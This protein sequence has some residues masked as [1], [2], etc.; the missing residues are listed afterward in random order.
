[1]IPPKVWFLENFDPISKV[2]SIFEVGLEV[3]LSGDFVLRSIK[4]F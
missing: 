4:F 1:M 2:G 3:S